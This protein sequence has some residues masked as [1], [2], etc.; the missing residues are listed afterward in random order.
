MQPEQLGQFT[1]D[2]HFP[3]LVAFAMADG[4]HALG[5]A[6]VLDPELD[7]LGG[8]GAGFQQGLQHQ[9]DAPALRVGLVEEAQLLLDRQ[10]V[11]AAA[12]FRGRMQAST[13]PG[14]LEH[15]LALG[16]IDALTDEDGGDRGRRC[17][18]WRP[19]SSLLFC[20]RGAN[21]WRAS[22]SV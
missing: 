17:A 14:S 12:T 15:G 6:D 5:Q 8:A 10:P 22:I 9:P 1:P 7:Q 13:L 11:H 2:R 19:W 21:Q 16:V 18:Q 3:P 4:D 20:R